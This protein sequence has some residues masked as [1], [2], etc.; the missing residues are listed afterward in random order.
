MPKPYANDLVAVKT[1]LGADTI[2]RDLQVSCS[3]L[4]QWGNTVKLEFSSTK[5]ELTVFTR[6]RVEPDFSMNINDLE[7]HPSYS[8]KYLGVILDQKLT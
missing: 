8:V 6:K 3:T 5:S 2:R 7:I 1:G 4:R